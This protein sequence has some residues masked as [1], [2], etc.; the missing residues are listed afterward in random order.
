[1]GGLHCTV[2]Y[3][4]K[5][6]GLFSS[7][8]ERCQWFIILLFCGS[9]GRFTFAKITGGRR[10]PVKPIWNGAY[11]YNIIPY[12]FI[13][14]RRTQSKTYNKGQKCKWWSDNK[15]PDCCL[16]P[17]Q[18][19]WWIPDRVK[20]ISQ[21][22][23]CTIVIRIN[24]FRVNTI[25][26]WRIDLVAVRAW[27]ESSE[28]LKFYNTERQWQCSNG[29]AVAWSGVGLWCFNIWSRDASKLIFWLIIS[30]MDYSGRIRGK[31]VFRSVISNVVQ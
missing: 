8:Y 13:R 1:M 27:D 18:R 15:T 12:G 21:R 20:T 30:E 7:K 3:V 25:A 5:H 24:R 4:H 2:T 28:S 31:W 10:R 9:C 11:F 23:S 26:A 22:R 17:L 19:G 14:K 16:L 29:G 6:H